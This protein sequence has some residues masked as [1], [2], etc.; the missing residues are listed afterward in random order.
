M[1]CF[2]LGSGRIFGAKNDRCFLMLFG[3][4]DRV[5]LSVPNDRKMIRNMTV[6]K[7]VRNPSSYR[8]EIFILSF[9]N[10][11]NASSFRTDS[12]RHTEMSA[13]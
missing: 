10:A 6:S 3:L 4:Y 11:M 1:P 9:H 13:L 12:P 8:T 7:R 5:I 2:S